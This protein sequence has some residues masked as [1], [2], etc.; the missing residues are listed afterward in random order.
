M[1]DDL[2]TIHGYRARRPHAPYRDERGFNIARID[3]EGDDP[4]ERRSVAAETIVSAPTGNARGTTPVGTGIGWVSP[5]N[6]VQFG[7]IHRYDSEHD[8]YEV[9]GG[10]RQIHGYE[11]GG[12]RHVVKGS[13]IDG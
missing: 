7:V 4:N 11:L 8:Y 9:Q 3:L 2:G 5:M 1:S 12:N 10:S 6:A 13:V